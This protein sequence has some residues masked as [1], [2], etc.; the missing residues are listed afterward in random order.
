MRNAHDARAGQ[1]H[2][3]VLAKG[4][5]PFM[6]QT[7]WIWVSAGSVLRL[8]P[9]IA[10]GAMVW[11]ARAIPTVLIG[12][13]GYVS[14]VD[15]RVVTIYRHPGYV[16]R[17]SNMHAT[18]LEDKN[19]KKC[20]PKML[21]RLSFPAPTLDDILSKDIFVCEPDGTPKWC[22]T[23][24]IW[25]PDRSRHC[26]E[27]D[28][29]VLKLDHFCPWVGGIVSEQ[30]MKHFILFNSYTF[31]HTTFD[32][33]LAAVCIAQRDRQRSLDG[34]VVAMLILG[35]FFMG[36]TGGIGF[37]AI[38][39]AL[40]NHTTVE[41]TAEPSGHRWNMALRVPDERKFAE[42]VRTIT[43]PHARA[44]ETS[45][46]MLRKLLKDVG[47]D[48]F[49]THLD[50]SSTDRKPPRTKPGRTFAIITSEAFANPRGCGMYENSCQVMGHNILGWFLPIEV[51]RPWFSHRAYISKDAESSTT[52]R[53]FF[54]TSIDVQIM[55]ARAGLIDVSPDEM[56]D[57]Y[58]RLEH[59]RGFPYLLGG[60]GAPRRQWAA[61]RAGQHLH[62][63][64]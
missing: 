11:A 55:K 31:L 60:A 64:P 4:D 42:G 44:N 45:P 53:S 18:T 59:R 35:L 36:L 49:I 46:D 58:G 24:S 16:E 56:G 30:S 15:T 9:I 62:E 3:C 13:I 47:E 20:S 48:S 8:W 14:W 51:D 2:W 63:T 38:L 57:Y 12:I 43:F 21:E 27:K 26:R 17:G 54:P 19:T 5:V 40:T 34:N 29:C 50:D 37:S 41:N 33:I 22:S 1:R 6:L 61:S 25:R 23:C 7:N 39:N 10:G 32:W 52:D 28:R